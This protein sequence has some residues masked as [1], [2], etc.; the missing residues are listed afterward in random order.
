MDH[1]L[2][3]EVGRLMVGEESY[4]NGYL[5][6]TPNV[7]S[8]Q[9]VITLEIYRGKHGIQRYGVRPCPEYNGIVTLD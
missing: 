2:C 6:G 7:Y 8:T 4:V 1:L 5:H 3:M 9:L